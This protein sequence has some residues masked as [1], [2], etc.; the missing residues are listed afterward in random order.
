MADSLIVQAI[1]AQRAAVARGEK[2]LLRDLARLWVPSY[3]YLQQQVTD[4][5]NVIQAQ[6][7]QGQPVWI[8][9]I[10]SLERYQTMMEQAR[11]T[12]DGYNRAALGRISG[13]EA[14]AVRIGG[15]NGRQLINLAEPDAPVW[16]RV[17]QRETRILSGML[18]EASPLSSLLNKSWGQSKAG[19]EEALSIGV[20][21]GQGSA[22][23]ADQM[24]K[25]VNIPYQRAQ[26]IART[27]VNRAYRESNV[28][29]M[30]ETRVTKGFRRMCY[31]PT[32][33][34]ACLMLD[35]E[36]YSVGA[37]PCD[38]P[39]GKC[40][41]VP[42]T[43][44]F[45]P[46]KDPSWERGQD[47]FS[48][49]DEETQRRIMGAGRFELWKQHGVDPKSM[50]Y[51]KENP[52]WGG[53]PT[54]KTLEEL[55]YG[56]RGTDI[57]RTFYMSLGPDQQIDWSG[58]RG[59]PLSKDQQ[60]ALMERAQES[61][62][63]IYA[64]SKF[65]GDASILREQIDAIA[66][67]KEEFPEIF[68]GHQPLTITFQ[69]F[70][71]QDSADFAKTK[72]L[73][74]T[75]NSFALRDRE[76]TE[77]QISGDFSFT[78]CAGISRHEVGH[79]LERT[80]GF[81]GLDLAYQAYENVFGPQISNAELSTFLEGIISS[82]ASMPTKNGAGKIRFSEIT[83]EILGY[84]KENNVFVN[85]FKSLIRKERMRWL[86]SSTHHG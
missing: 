86:N 78:D 45:D 29:A 19:I 82:A 22:W 3:R 84:N 10:H 39:N 70:T 47:W 40:S 24:M 5:M 59:A 20:S 26:L 36:I 53:S 31:P 69:E 68:E 58:T 57:P 72:N 52:I 64:I 1:K 62:I 37:Q 7:D 33:C 34:F 76:F 50:V 60:A 14:D 6:R 11:R 71:G 85:E 77:K 38:H 8:G 42:V 13:A 44:H 43:K 49:Q 66:Q 55:G 17:N 83:S 65:D 80:Y 61:G 9:Y 75:F 54:M 21:T 46:A 28:E 56:Y 4:L 67:Y 30:R 25:A 79:I 18:S 2:Q 41:F 16:T 32:A 27:E 48:R 81:K 63:K 15:D 23:I 51:I 12:I 73:T 74:I 35:G